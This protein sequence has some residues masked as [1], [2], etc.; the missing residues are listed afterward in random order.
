M[1]TDSAAK[2]YLQPMKEKEG[3]DEAGVHSH[4]SVPLQSFRM[5]KVMFGWLLWS[6]NQVEDVWSGHF[7]NDCLIKSITGILKLNIMMWCISQCFLKNIFSHLTFMYEQIHLNIDEMP[8]GFFAVIS[9][10]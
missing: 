9:C 6:L 8:L 2:M 7:R 1:R 10:N 3:E 4:D 5:S